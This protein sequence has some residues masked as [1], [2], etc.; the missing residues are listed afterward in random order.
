MKDPSLPPLASLQEIRSSRIRQQVILL[1]MVVMLLLQFSWELFEEQ[2]EGWRGEE[3]ANI[4]VPAIQITI[5]LALAA[6]FREQIRDVS[7]VTPSG[8][9]VRV[10]LYRSF[11]LRVLSIAFFLPTVFAG[12]LL[13]LPPSMMTVANLLVFG[14][15]LLSL[16]FAFL[17]AV[18]LWRRQIVRVTADFHAGR[19][20][21]GLSRLARAGRILG[22][23]EAPLRAALLDLEPSEASERFVDE[24]LLSAR[25]AG[26][27]LALILTRATHRLDRED[28]AG[29]EEMMRLALALFPRAPPLHRLLAEIWLDSGIEAD[30]LERLE[31]AHDLARRTTPF[32]DIQRLERA[33]SFAS[34]AWG[35]ARAGQIDL[36]RKILAE[37][38]PPDSLPGRAELAWR[39]GRAL[40][41]AGDPEGAKERYTWG[42]TL[43]GRGALRCK[44]ALGSGGQGHAE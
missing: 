15:A 23:M 11:V 10:P 39:Q 26:Q 7:L 37:I 24:A 29:A 36:A 19:R 8:P 9:I 17:C 16:M 38:D 3:I 2:I 6:L 12:T 21:Q 30:A 4:A 25:P 14:V 44:R 13:L 42:A 22:P 1:A 20:E 41:A 18:L 31:L 43:P 27:Q 34:Y 28:H 33:L 40:A 5:M 35:L 32:A